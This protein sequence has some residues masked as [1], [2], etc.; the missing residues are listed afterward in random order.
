MRIFALDLALELEGA[1]L[2][3]AQDFLTP[4]LSP[5]SW[6]GTRNVPVSICQGSDPMLLG[7]ALCGPHSHCSM[8][9]PQGTSRVC[10]VLKF[11][12]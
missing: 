2:G 7:N 8:L 6:D 9:G 12:L 3:L 1:L 11:V 10:L 4:C 5:R